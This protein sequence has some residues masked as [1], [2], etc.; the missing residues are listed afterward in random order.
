MDNGRTD[1][2]ELLHREEGDLYR[3]KPASPAPES[4]P[5]QRIYIACQIKLPLH[6]K[7]SQVDVLSNWGEVRGG[8][9]LALPGGDKIARRKRSH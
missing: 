6:G 7:N 4:L 9:I 8:A 3:H 1:L 5:S 2:W